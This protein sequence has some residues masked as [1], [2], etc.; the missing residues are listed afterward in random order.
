MGHSSLG[1]VFLEK[2]KTN[3]LQ[4]S[5]RFS[6]DS[7]SNVGVQADPPC[8]RPSQWMFFH[9]CLANAVQRLSRS[10][11]CRLLTQHIASLFVDA[12]RRL[13]AGREARKLFLLPEEV[14]A[15]LVREPCA[16]S[17]VSFRCVLCNNNAFYLIVP[18]T[19]KSQRGE[20]CWWW[21]QPDKKRGR[22]QLPSI[23]VAGVCRLL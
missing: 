9:P 19:T 12:V 23:G 20:W 5:V 4:I 17:A 15:V 11:L 10:L 21:Q 2:A 1:S 7:K 16:A 14:V 18:R 3:L 8:Q 22:Q 13:A 6:G